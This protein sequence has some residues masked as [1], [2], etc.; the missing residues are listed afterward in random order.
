M[1]SH[2]SW[3]YTDAKSGIKMDTRKPRRR[4]IDNSVVPMSRRSENVPH[5]NTSADGIQPEFEITSDNMKHGIRE[6]DVNSAQCDKPW[7]LNTAELNHRTQIMDFVIPQLQQKLANVGIIENVHTSQ[8]PKPY[9]DRSEMRFHR[10]Y[11][12]Y[13]ECRTSFRSHD[14][15]LGAY[16]LTNAG[17]SVNK[18]THDQ[19]STNKGRNIKSTTSVFRTRDGLVD[20]GVYGQCDQRTYTN[21]SG[22]NHDAGQIAAVIQYE[23][24]RS[25]HEI[26]RRCSVRSI[27]ERHAGDDPVD[28]RRRPD[29]RGDT[30]MTTDTDHWRAKT[31]AP[32]GQ[33]EHRR[34]AVPQVHRHSSFQRS[35][36]ADDVRHFERLG[37][38][39]YATVDS[40]NPRLAVYVAHGT[41]VSLSP[42][43]EI[44]R[45]HSLIETNCVTETG[46]GKVNMD[47]ASS[48]QYPYDNVSIKS[49]DSDETLLCRHSVGLFD[50]ANVKSDKTLDR[51]Y[52]NSYF[53][54]VDKLLQKKKQSEAK[55]E[56]SIMDTK[57]E[58]AHLYE[59]SNKS[60]HEC[61]LK[62]HGLE[63][64]DPH[65]IELEL[66]RG[67]HDDANDCNVQPDLFDAIMSDFERDKLKTEDAF[68]TR[69]YDGEWLRTE[70][71][72]IVCTHSYRLPLIIGFYRHEARLDAD[73]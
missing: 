35:S 29:D 27:G 38:N 61:Y 54:N 25:E 56:I 17:Q 70:V 60:K 41:G 34:K 37:T 64:K 13:P 2:N 9:V 65:C 11:H 62:S 68:I 5:H 42:V 72:F 7:E 28:H 67:V 63:M 21:K 6:T 24:K 44:C 10:V 45:R 47:T 31:D 69:L 66:S 15:Q 18:V 57:H 19:H 30:L 52:E 51:R 73:N 36:T 20:M 48:L 3:F 14:H 40:P 4:I 49:F 16:R 53:E 71:S 43:T 58:V 33:E 59:K 50:N 39:D 46:V 22:H 23:N 1:P 8:S 26:I 32:R 55:S 12:E